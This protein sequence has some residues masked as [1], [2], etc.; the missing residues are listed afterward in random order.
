MQSGHA[1]GQE[2]RVALLQQAGSA[3]Q[4]QI[5]CLELQRGPICQDSQILLNPLHVQLRAE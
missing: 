3:E 2:H 1:H 5:T 4:V